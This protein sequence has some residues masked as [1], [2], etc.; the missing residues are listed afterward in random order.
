MQMTTT[1]AKE[2]AVDVTYT[3]SCCSYDRKIG[4]YVLETSGSISIPPS[5][6]QH[7]FRHV[8][9]LTNSS[10]MNS[11]GPM[12]F[13]ARVYVTVANA[14]LYI[15]FRSRGFS[16]TLEDIKAYYFKCPALV[17]NF[18]SYPEKIAPTRDSMS[19]RITGTCVDQSLPETNSA[20]NVMICYANGTS[21]TVGMCQCI[22]GYQNTSVSSCSGKSF[23]YLCTP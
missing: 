22:A 15:A 8:T 19:L 7:D 4:L 3:L 2:I 14:Q 5:P 20:D 6:M 12:R 16:G 13:I 1:P 21:K 11:P 10:V 9:D 17:A 23:E 18:V